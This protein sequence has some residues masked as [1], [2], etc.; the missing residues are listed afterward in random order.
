MPRA[1]NLGDHLIALNEPQR[2]LSK[3]R[4]K[5]EMATFCVELFMKSTNAS[6]DRAVVDLR[7]RLRKAGF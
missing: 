2:K 1:K 3:A 4:I 5:A 6:K 7:A